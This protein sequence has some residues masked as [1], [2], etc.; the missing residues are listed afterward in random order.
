MNKRGALAALAIAQFVM[1][2]DQSVMNVSITQL[3]RD[4]D[5]TVTTI[6]A[7]ITLYC[8]IMAMF[9]MTGGKIG[10][11][12]GRRRAFMIG[13]I[14]YGC[15][16]L[17]TSLAPNVVV[18]ALGWSVLEGLG[19]ALVLPAMAALVAGNYAGAARRQ[20]YA[21]LGGVAG[22]G[23][24]VGPI[25]GGYATTNLSWRY[26]FAGE[27]V[28]VI[29]ILALLPRVNDAKL[30]GARPHLDGFGALLSAAALGLFV[31]GIQMSSSWGLVQ[32]KGSPVSP[33]GF[34]LSIYLIGAA[35]LLG[36]GFVIWQRR[37]ERLGTDPLVHLDLLQVPPLRAGLLSMFNQN[38]I[39][40]GAFFV[41]P[42]YLQLVQ[43]LDALQ[44]GIKLLPVS[45]A[46]FLASAIGSRLSSRMPVR[47]IVQVGLAVVT[48]ALIVLL[49][50]L[51]PVLTDA[52]FAF[53]MALLG[54]GMGLVVSQLGN[55]VQSSV[56]SSGRGEA[57]GLQYT[58]QQ[59]GSSLGVALIG[60][61]VLTSLTGNFVRIIE[62]DQRIS[63]DLSAQVSTQV[64]NGVDFVSTNEVEAAA[65]EAGLDEAATAAIVD[66]Y[67]QAQIKALKGG[68]LLSIFLALIALLGT[69]NLPTAVSGGDDRTDG[70]SDDAGDPALPVL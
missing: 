70:R 4:F 65:T 59:L 24:A 60:A 58:G 42:L 13:L 67:G 46:M 34:S 49:F 29:A 41:M 50:T 9:M 43:G 37:R 31:F 36:Y 40:M 39:L 61:M 66:D 12:I 64:G 48:A 7:V 56:D 23:I 16:S 52:R 5:T 68:V 3:V 28:L 17:I 15:G 19:A 30:E 22:A 27:V 10:D 51:E 11:L 55:V 38:L 44:T 20:A 33:F 1:V 26:V 6:Q 62:D 47:R 57:G 54:V 25:L 18:L 69:R 8:L 14:I 21:V 35:I 63:S 53:A 2:L 45:I 32:P